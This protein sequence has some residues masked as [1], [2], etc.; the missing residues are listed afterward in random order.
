MNCYYAHSLE[1][2][3]ITDWELL[4]DH[5]R[6]VAELAREY[7]AGF[8]AS[9]WGSLVGWWHDVG[10]YS[11]EF[12]A[13]LRFENGFEAHLEQYTGRVDHSTAGAQHAVKTFPREGRVLAYCI[14]GHHAGLADQMSDSGCSGLSDRLLKQIPNFSR[15]P[16][17]VLAVP[18][19][20]KPALSFEHGCVQ[21]ASFQLSFF[22]RM[23]F[24]CLVDADF[25]ATESFM[26]PDRGAQRLGNLP[27]LNEM[28]TTL[29]Q[30]LS[31]LNTSTDTTV[32]I[33][34]SEVLSACRCKAIEKPG[35]FS[36]TV[37]TG[38]GKTLSSLAFAL[39]HANENS[40]SRVIYAIPFTSIIE[41]TASVFR[42]VFQGLSDAT[43]LE[44]HSSLDPD[45]ETVASRMASENWDAP[46]VV[47]TNVQFFESLYAAKTSRCRKLHRICNSVIIL[48]EA[49][50]IPV[51]LLKPTLAVIRELV[52][53]YGCTVVL[54]TATQPSILKREGFE[55]GLEEATEILPQPERLYQTMK[56]VS[57]RSI[58]P[59]S[60][61]QIVNCLAEHSQFLCIVNT[62]LHASR[63]YQS[64]RLH[65]GRRSEGL[66]DDST[67]SLVSGHGAKGLFHLST[68]M[69][70][71]HRHDTLEEIRQRLRD[72]QQCQVISTQLIEAGVDVDFPIVY[73]ALTGV[74]SI[75][76][77]AG[78]C[79]REGKRPTGDVVVFE[80]T[81]IKLRGYLRTVAE[82][83]AELIAGQDSDRLDLLDLDIVQQYFQLHYRKHRGGNTSKGDGWDK[84]DVMGCFPAPMN[85]MHFNFRTAAER[86]RWI[87]DTAET[88]FVPYGDGAKLIDRLREIDGDP[89]HASELRELLRRL[90]RYSVGLYTNV[91][92]SLV[93]TDIEVLGSGY[94]VLIN[95]TCYDKNVGFQID[96][97]GFYEPETLIV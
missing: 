56:R 66:V 62:R 89:H 42:N 39:K 88:V 14:A 48:D 35:L 17:E 41:Q 92:K 52:A 84:R 58:G 81:E 59:Q 93:G 95:P 82:S 37:P 70:G 67:N 20:S 11:A 25:L 2:R 8:K 3:P 33:A 73:R 76:Q 63:L 38:G 12:Q 49:Q 85:K 27:T 13:Y 75:A 24:S 57:I 29:D 77:A 94:A 80:P 16:S 30:H 40:M 19:L 43:V 78:R 45:L 69:C 96:N 61:E 4:E 65:R 97:V 71:Q 32:G 64:L 5:L 6:D 22:T 90:Q 51:E 72:D 7:A 60:N 1:S 79:N 34:R 26:S 23:L 10:K 9:D 53:D 46:L 15:A 18:Q 44:H 21:R 54:C 36:L 91:F 47:T 55:I 50:S 28:Q 68:L 87:E 31:S 83:A 86:F 74:D